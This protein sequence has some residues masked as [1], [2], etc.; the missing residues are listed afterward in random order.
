MNEWDE[1]SVKYAI[2]IKHE[3]GRLEQG[4][5]NAHWHVLANLLQTIWC[6]DLTWYDEGHLLDVGCGA[7]H[8]SII[9]SKLMGDGM[10]YLGCEPSERMRAV[11]TKLC[12]DAGVNDMDILKV[13]DQA[14]GHW[15]QIVM[16]NG[17]LNHIHEWGQAL[18][19]MALL[20][21]KYVILHRLWVYMDDSPSCGILK[22][23]YDQSI[24]HMRINQ[25]EMKRLMEREGFE[26]KQKASSNGSGDP[27]A[28]WTFLFQ[29]RQHG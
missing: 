19:M 26:L 12:P 27:L 5:I 2:G 3:L 23:A 21:E 28:G 16:S 24:W 15:A 18:A 1:A 9:L 22:Q 25:N 13:P 4:I 8:A 10:S 29:R 17:T 20:S 7:G 6:E 11:G 14:Q